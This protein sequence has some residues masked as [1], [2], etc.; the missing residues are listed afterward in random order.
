M[1]QYGKQNINK[2]DIKCVVDVLKSDWLTQ[3]PKVKEFEDAL[4]HYCGSK[5]AVVCSN[6]TAALHL[7][8]LTAGLKKGDEV[9]TTPNTFVATSNMLL[10]VG[11]K[12]VFC[13]IRL[14]TYNIDEN[15]IEKTVTKK[16]K[17]IVPVHFAGQSCEMEKI[18]QIAKKNNLI[19]I[20]DACHALGAEYKGVK[21]GSCKYSD[22]TVFSFHPVKPITTGEGGAILTNNKSYY[23][24]LLTLRSH[25][26]HKDRSGK[27]VMTELGYNYRM[28][29]LQ[30]ALGIS[31][32]KRLDKFI[33]KRQQV[34]KW[35][36]GELK[37]IKEI[38]L[39]FEIEENLSGWHLYVIR[40]KNPKLRDNLFKFFHKNGI[41]VNFHY[42]AVCSHPHYRRNGY[43]KAIKNM[44]I[45]Q[46][47]CI[48]LPC[49]TQLDR[50]KIKFITVIINN[51]YIKY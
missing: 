28:T 32:L 40:V 50:N 33:K 37:N 8:Y 21:V 38:I 30:A 15:K 6:G 35:Y 49:Y 26:I 27:N 10:A 23:Q 44:E 12:P 3:G 13:D 7:A 9:I 47:S 22:M 45:Y 24:K 11:A 20:E 46:R 18:K 29:D 36:E 4:A 51:F 41:C 16:T 48:T 39:P 19:V 5:Y 1:I 42:P 14:D 2:E 25:G 31:Q 43:K 34:V 17:A